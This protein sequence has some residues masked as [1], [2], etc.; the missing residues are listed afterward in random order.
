MKVVGPSSA[1]VPRTGQTISYGTRDDGALQKGVA[2]PNPRFTDN[3]NGTVTDNLT[4]LIWLKNANSA[5]ARRDWATA[6]TDCNTLAANGTTLTDGSVAGDWR[7]PN[8]RELFSLID[9]GKYNPALPT[10]HPFTDVKGGTDHYWSSTTKT[11]T[12]GGA[13]Y[14]NLR[15]GYVNPG[16]KPV[17]LYVWPVRGGLGPSSAGVP[18][19]GQTISYGTRDD[20]ALQKGVAWPNPRFTDNANGTVTDNLTGLIWLKNG[21]FFSAQKNWATAL[22]DCNTLAANGTTLTDGSVAG[23]WRLPNKRELFSLIDDS[24]YN[25]SLPTGHPFADVKGYYW[26]STTYAEGT[27]NAW[28]VKILDGWVYLDH[29]L[30][31]AYLWP[32]RG[33]Q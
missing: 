13:W 18:R 2:W 19:T 29:K 31:T 25:S 12:T 1:G 10:G 6:L 22:A 3:A 21:N 20:G 24:K 9:D 26:S 16:S 32:V 11:I 30:N 33:G 15:N 27:D 17:T 8:K 28:F 23:D 14:W 4:G 5:N 7:L